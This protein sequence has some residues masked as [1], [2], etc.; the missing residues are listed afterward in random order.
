MWRSPV[1]G[2]WARVRAPGRA[3][4]ER[5]WAA[6]AW[7]WDRLGGVPA[8]PAGSLLGG[9]ASV[10]PDVSEWLAVRHH[11][12][13]HR[14]DLVRAAAA[15]YPDV[16]RVEGTALLTRRSWLPAEP[17]PLTGL[18]LELGDA[19]A[20]VSPPAAS[21]G[22]LLPSLDGGDP[23]RTYADAVALLQRPAVFEDRPTYCLA[24]ADLIASPAS[25]SFTLGSYFDG[26]NI[27]EAAGHEFAAQ[28]HA[29]QVPTLEQLP[30]RRQVG[31]PTDLS[32]R[33]ASSGITT[34]TIRAGERG[35]EA[36]FLVHW[37]DPAKVATSPGMFQ[38]VPVGVFQPASAAP[39]R[40]VADLD[41]WRCMA[42]EY[43]EELLGAEEDP[44]PDYATWPFFGELEAA[45]EDGSCRPFLLGIGVDPLSF[46]TDMLTA[47]VFAPETFDRFFADL[48]INNAEGSLVVGADGQLGSPF[49]E[50]EVARLANL[51][52]MQAAGAAALRLAWQHRRTLVG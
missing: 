6:T 1:I 24:S 38:L 8:H 37:R 13:Q 29:G 51:G 26:F 47:V 4:R 11:L 19:D 41:L 30:L 14:G 27:G 2:R 7:S 49:V 50:A 52:S 3:L 23:V 39:E 31:D 35:E 36:R 28:H 5:W 45:C 32:G 33:R 12:R 10:R 25:L 40:R 46:A 44:D 15:L 48:V 20:H 9:A 18:V 21:V 22:H 43:A 16:P 42:R 17:L 34:V